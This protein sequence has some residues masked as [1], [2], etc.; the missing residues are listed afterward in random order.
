MSVFDEL[1]GQEA[2]IEELLRAAVAARE[3]HADSTAE[4]TGAETEL[5]DNSSAMTHAWL[6][7]GPPGSGRSLAAKTFA[8][9]LEC[10]GPVPGCGQCPQCKAVMGNNHPDVTFVSTD[11]VTIKADE[12]RA[13]VAQSYVAPVE[14][15]YRVFIV[16][17]ADR[18][19]P[20]TTNVLLKAIEEPAPRTV[21]ILCTV[22]A[23]DVLPTIRSRCRNINLVTPSPQAV[24]ELLVRR[25][26]VPPELALVA[27]QAAQSHIGVARAL[28]TDPA[29]AALR[30]T[31]L[32]ALTEI[33]SVGEA[34]LTAQLLVDPEKMYM[35]SQGSH[36]PGEGAGE[37]AAAVHNAPSA[38]D[39]IEAEQHRRMEELGL[40]PNGR[41]PAAVK[42]QVATDAHNVKRRQTRLHRDMLDR[43]LIYIEGFFRDVL[44]RQLG[45][46]VPVINA[47]FAEEIEQRA[48][49]STAEETIA[50]MDTLAVARRRLRSNVAPVLAL[51]AALVQLVR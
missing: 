6:F 31:T 25:D 2:A 3:T 33:H 26:G 27:A 32:R 34:V 9:A 21:W 45:A 38:A 30:R 48:Q 37:E 50:T 28:A 4:G 49:L 5:A 12:V 13:Y 1:V 43:E 29:A 14:G 22:A 44:V 10:T 42:S 8:A 7:T 11:L 17:D 16:E 46:E 47:D 39:L 36:N 24:A 41:V 15:A 18:M 19:L 51:E 35:D 40:D 20:R 23:A